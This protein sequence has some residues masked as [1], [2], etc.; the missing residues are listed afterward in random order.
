[1][2][3]PK[4]IIISTDC[5]VGYGLVANQYFLLESSESSSWPIRMQHSCLY[6]PQPSPFHPNPV[7]DPT[8]ATHIVRLTF[9]VFASILISLLIR[10]SHSKSK[11]KEKLWLGCVHLHVM[12]MSY[13]YLYSLNKHLDHFS[14]KNEIRINIVFLGKCFKNSFEDLLFTFAPKCIFKLN[15][16][17]AM[18]TQKCLSG[19]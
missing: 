13:S 5:S 9:L 10:A 19:N 11:Q 6:F 4:G 16:L 14:F 12:L 7:P 8:L 2:V 1:M 3:K 15:L 18:V 17:K